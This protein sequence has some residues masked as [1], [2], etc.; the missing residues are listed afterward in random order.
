MCIKE[1]DK[2]SYNKFKMDQ[3]HQNNQENN[4]QQ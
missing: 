3:N 1:K 2:V 4:Q